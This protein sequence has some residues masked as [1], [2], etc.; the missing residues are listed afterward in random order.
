M[1]YSMKKKIDE[2]DFIKNENLFFVI[3]T[4]ENGKTGH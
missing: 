4:S 3:D 2:M 1:T